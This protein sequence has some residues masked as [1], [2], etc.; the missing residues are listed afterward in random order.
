M[1]F[2]LPYRSVFAEQSIAK[3]QTHLELQANDAY[4]H[5]LRYGKKVTSHGF[6]SN[7]SNSPS[8]IR[9]EMS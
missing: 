8:G 6:L 3:Y 5:Q 2:Q 9:R 1:L 4:N 7:I